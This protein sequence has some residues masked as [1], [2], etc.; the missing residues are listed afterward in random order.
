MVLERGRENRSQIVLAVARRREMIFW[1]SPRTSKQARP[2]VS[3]PTA[4]AHGQALVIVVDSSEKYPYRFGHQQA[5]TMRRRLPAGDDGVELGGAVVAAV[6]RKTVE[7]LV[8]SVLAGKLTFALAELSALP[9]AALVVE[10]RYSRLFKLPYA[11]GARLPMPSPKRRPGFPRCR[12]CSASLVTWPRNGS[13]GGW[14]PARW[15]C[16]RTTPHI[17]KRR[18]LPVPFAGRVPLVASPL[19]RCPHSGPPRCESGPLLGV[20]RFPAKGESPS[21]YSGRIKQ[22]TRRSGRR[23]HG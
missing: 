6:E 4:R 21:R 11:P 22:R 2:A 19:R 16:P 5:T 15:S 13:I 7:D 23:M 8:G 14:V 12:S 17:W 9:R 20:S 10:D 3:L 18:L 1:Q